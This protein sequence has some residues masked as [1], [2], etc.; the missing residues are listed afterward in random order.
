MNPMSNEQST[1]HSKDLRE[2]LAVHRQEIEAVLN[3]YRATN[4]RLFGSVARGEANAASDIDLLVD[5]DPQCGNVLFRAGGLSDE[6]RRILGRKVDVFS[7][8]LMKG[9]I[10]ASALEDAFPV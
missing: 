4:L 3:H 9:D 1:S 8:Q 2:L 7:T 6:F 5:L 10:A